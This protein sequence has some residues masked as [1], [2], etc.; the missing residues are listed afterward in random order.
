MD[1]I[2][3]NDISVLGYH[4]VY[5]EERT[6]GQPF[7]ADVTLCL[8][9]DR[10][11]LTDC[12]EDT[13]NYAE[14]AKVVHE[15]ISGPP[16][17]LI[18]TLAREIALRVLAFPRVESTIVTVHK[19][20][21]DLSG[22]SQGVS[23]TIE[24]DRKWAQR[25]TAKKAEAGKSVTSSMRLL[26][27]MKKTKK[28]G[29]SVLPKRSHKQ[30]TSW[31]LSPIGKR[32]ASGE[33]T[34]EPVVLALGGN[35]GDVRA[36]LM[37][38]IEKIID[39]PDL[40]V[41][42]V[43]P[44]VRTAAFLEPNQDPQADYL[45]CVVT[46]K[47][48]LPLG[49]LLKFLQS[50][51]VAAGRVMGQH[52]QPRPLDVDII[53]AGNLISDDAEL[54]LPHPRAHE[55]I[56]V[57]YPWAQIENQADL[58]GYGKVADLL[59]RIP[60]SEI[61]GEWD[62][63]LEHDPKIDL[64]PQALRGQILVP[65]TLDSFDEDE[66]LEIPAEGI[67][68]TSAISSS[69]DFEQQAQNKVSTPGLDSEVHRNFRERVPQRRP[70]S[71]LFLQADKAHRKHSGPASGTGQ[72]PDYFDRVSAEEETKQESIL[73]PEEETP[74]LTE[75]PATRT[76]T[77]QRRAVVRPTTTGTIPVLSADALEELKNADSA[78]VDETSP[79]STNLSESSEKGEG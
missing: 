24:R 54:T 16:V 35:Q 55:R 41:L 11:G 79:V 22:V 6:Q 57:L 45:N 2:F 37:L 44:L 36:N 66:E 51:E 63:W 7:I 74:T 73:E 48:S 18:E 20:K 70:L 26:G 52:W 17:D 42:E 21:A 64:E 8:D 65:R 39:N 75:I 25:A 1:K 32:K 13:V 5:P 34:S 28:T 15:V 46:V 33:V 27:G 53:K 4:G 29:T 43:S 71:E 40:E 49:K 14:V 60:E 56:F 68:G 78:V 59:A 58:P 30:A 47:T 61:L 3:I 38:A 77:T 9:C 10:A 72:L 12:L 23:I 76:T 31:S 19:P 62:D 50:L 67:G 69:Q